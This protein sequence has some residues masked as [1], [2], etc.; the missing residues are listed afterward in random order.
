MLKPL[1]PVVHG[2]ILPSSSSVLVSGALGG[3]QVALLVNGDRVGSAFVGANGNL[4][5]GLDRNLAPGEP[6]VAVQEIGG[7]ESAPSNNPVT[8]IDLPI[9]LPPPAFGSPVTECMDHVLLVSLVPGATVTLKMSTT[10]LT[11][12]EAAGTSAW[13]SFN[14]APLVAGQTLSAVQSVDAQTS[15]T[16]LSMPL[17]SVSQREG[18]P[19]PVIA[20]PL[21][22]CD[23]A[24]LV[25]SMVP[26]GEL[27]L[28]NRG[29][30]QSWVNI[31][32]T[33][34]ATGVHPLQQGALKARQRL[35]GCGGVSSD[36]DVPVGP[37][38]TPPAPVLQPFCPD[39][40]RVVITG[41]KPDGVLT[42]WSKV[43]DQPAET[44][45]G[46]VGIGA[47]T[48]QV[49][50][51]DEIG[52]SGD[53][54]AIVARQTLCGLTSP[55][56]SSLEFARPGSGALPPPT[57][58]IVAPLLDCMRA[59]PTT[60]L[61]N[62]VLTQAFSQGSGQ[63]LSDPI[64]VT[65]PTTRIPVWFPLVDGDKVVV[66]Q[67]GCSAPSRTAVERVQGLPSPLTPPKI[68]TPV[69]P[70]DRSVKVEK[71]LPGARVHLLVDWVER[72][73]T[74]QTWTGETTLQL[75]VALNEGQKLWAVQVM[76]SKMS[77]LEG[78]PVIVSKG[79][80]ELEVAPSS[81]P[82]GKATSFVLNARD[83]DTGQPVTGLPV[84]LGGVPV[85]IIGSPFAWTPPTS[86]T[87]ATGLV[88][89]G[90]AY[91]N[92]GFTIAIRQAV[93]LTLNLFPGPTVEPG[94]V[95][96]SGVVW[97]VT[98]HWG[99]SAVTVNANVGTAMVPPPP[100][101]ENRVSVSLAFKAHLQ[102]EIGGIV[103]PPDV[104]EISGYLADVALTGLSHALSARF[105]YQATDVPIVDEDGQVTGWETKLAAGAQLF[106]IT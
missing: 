7:E 12:F 87:S 49:D 47:S 61:F 34:W 71:C 42:L 60:N 73:S 41:L 82:G 27:E 2:P 54:M 18:L 64:V 97:T 17:A 57:P 32:E 63:P 99:A 50:L 104:I 100:A 72:A 14:P 68:L 40:R 10:L 101:G 11:Q 98:P 30:A 3:A 92:A 95:W 53:I 31:A 77:D 70:G 62:G 102:G 67:R 84:V 52:G 89:G 8:V 24:V 43:W 85:G 5:V 106:S 36:V 22:A 74:D 28:E 1:A 20:G 78:Q 56:G 83:K 4:W 81:A 15:A 94:K 6:V 96:H 91:G 103:W 19:V 9:P 66:L 45:I 23:T 37:A 80:L 105:W 58:A 16:A 39:A 59:V 69:R 51:P 76:C 55:P 25:S 13:A 35:P 75:P 46:S 26:A 38:V 21:H 65:S 33:Y 79:R 93:P 88:Q 29:N 86:G 44:E 90:I 48:A